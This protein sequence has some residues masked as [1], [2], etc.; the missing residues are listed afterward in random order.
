M[1]RFGLIICALVLTSLSFPARVIAARDNRISHI[2]L[3]TGNV[4]V[5]TKM[6]WMRLETTPFPLYSG[7]KVVTKKGRS[8]I[9][10]LDG[11]IIKLDMD[12][13]F[14]VIEKTKK[15]ELFSKNW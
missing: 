3:Y 10:F 4:L 8:E 12:T 5:R 1:Q 7:D 9:L 14:K 2:Y 11:S 6:K 13:N 15:R